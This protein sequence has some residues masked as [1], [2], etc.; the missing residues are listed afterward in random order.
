MCL[1]WEGLLNNFCVQRGPITRF[2]WLLYSYLF[3]GC[4]DELNSIYVL[5]RNKKPSGVMSMHRC[6]VLGLITQSHLTLWD[7]MDCSPPGSSVHK[8]SPG[9]NIG[10]DCHALLQEIFP[11]QGSNPGLPHCRWI[12]YCLSP[13][14]VGHL[15]YY[16][17]DNILCKTDL[18]WVQVVFMPFRA[19]FISLLIFLKI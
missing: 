6:T 19:D 7:P 8:D 4:Q 11:M 1:L 9:K 17:L 13:D 15:L 5:G 3:L 2:L 14:F 12:L 10:E 18:I 16:W